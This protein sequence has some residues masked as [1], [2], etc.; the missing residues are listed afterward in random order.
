MKPIFLS[1]LLLRSWQSVVFILTLGVTMSACA[2]TTWKEEVA[3]HDGSKIIVTRSQTRGGRHEIGQEVPVAEHIITFAA[4]KSSQHITWKSTYGIDINDKSLQPIM[5]DILN[6]TPYIATRPA[7]CI[8]YNKWDRPNPPYVF[9]KYDGKDW[10]RIPL[11]EFP[12]EFKE[13][14]LV[15]SMQAH[16]SKLVEE[17]RKLGFVPVG[18]IRKLNKTL[19]EELRI[20]AREPITHGPGNIAAS[21]G[22]MV[23]D[24]KGGWIGIGWFKKQPSY[25]ACLK[26]CEQ[27][28]MTAQYCPCGTLFK[29]KQ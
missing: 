2:S 16:E 27:E 10:Q 8:A 9:F 15:V 17:D 23:Y 25:E 20:I 5:L 1:S 19:P 22:Q 13:A 24:G 26:Y 12:S 3:L 6:A 4:P 28:K 21:C 14:N 7:G 29:E 11:T 18:S